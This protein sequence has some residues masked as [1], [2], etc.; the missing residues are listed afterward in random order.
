MSIGKMDADIWF[1]P[2]L[3]RKVLCVNGIQSAGAP[4]RLAPPL[5]TELRERCQSWLWSL[6]AVCQK[7]IRLGAP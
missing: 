4:P 7:K 2:A 3:P 1:R 6:A 5:L